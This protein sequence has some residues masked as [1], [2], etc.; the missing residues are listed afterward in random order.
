LFVARF[1]TEK[2]FQTKEEFLYATLREAILTCA[3]APGEKLII[4]RLSEEFGVSPIPLRTALQRLEMEGWV[5]IVPFA[6]AVVSEIT[7]AEIDEVF[8]VLEALERAAFESAAERAH[9]GLIPE[10]EFVLLRGLNDLM[11]SALASHDDLAWSELNA[12]FHLKI[13]GITGMRLLA[14]FTRQAFDRWARLRRYYFPEGAPGTQSGAQAD[15][16]K[17]CSLLFSGE[18]NALGELVAQHNR[19]AREL[20]TEQLSRSTVKKPE[21][22]V[23]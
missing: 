10:E 21:L 6:G 20:Y 19:S 4:D 17:M 18:I 11:E 3:L 15:H 16:A 12:Q 8:A 14:D 13:A 1:K 22:G 7:T 9:E 5:R 23:E 2:A